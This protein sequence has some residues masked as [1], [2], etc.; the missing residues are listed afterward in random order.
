MLEGD[1][2]IQEV[3]SPSGILCQA[4]TESTMVRALEGHTWSVWGRGWHLLYL[5]GKAEGASVGGAVPDDESARLLLPQQIDCWNSLWLE[6]N[7]C[8]TDTIPIPIGSSQRG[9]TT[10]C[11][12]EVLSSCLLTAGFA[13]FLFPNEAS[14]SP[15]LPQAAICHLHYHH[16]PGPHLPAA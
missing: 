13:Y 14:R 2:G 8:H 4:G 9:H 5:Q 1:R 12:Q 7:P 11:P 3:D 10:F 15:T 16:D 6:A